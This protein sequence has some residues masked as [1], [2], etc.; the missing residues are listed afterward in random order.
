MPGW[1]ISSLAQRIDRYAGWPATAQ[2]VYRKVQVSVQA[3][4]GDPAVD[5]SAVK[6]AAA[7]TLL[8]QGSQS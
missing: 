5:L 2:V 3:D 4:G 8:L 7:R 1:G 6:R